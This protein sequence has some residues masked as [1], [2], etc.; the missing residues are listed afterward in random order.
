[1]N[2]FRQFRPIEQDEFF[3]A[4]AD[5]ATGGGDYC[6]CP[7]LSTKHL[8]FPLL[9]HSN[10]S[11]TLMTNLLHPV[12]ERI[13]DATGFAPVIA[14][15]T[16][17][18]GIFEF[19][20][21]AGL[22]RANKYRIYKMRTYGKIENAE[23]SSIGW[24]TNTA[25]RPA[26][27]KDWKDAVDNQLVRIYDKPTISEHYSFIINKQ[28]KPEAEANSHDDLVITHAGCWQLYQTEKPI[29][30]EPYRQTY[31]RSKWVIQ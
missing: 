21:L 11:A 9:Y 30:S 23:E 2:G 7:F 31:N 26:M 18:G 3:V 16:N 17:N 20:R 29:R 14:Y 25:T 27:L 12:L 19:E 15:E 24:N 8:D 6:A 4:F 10:K 28:G 1:V 13:H 5:T 22:N